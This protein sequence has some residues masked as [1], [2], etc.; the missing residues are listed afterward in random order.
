MVDLSGQIL[1][2]IRLVLCGW[3]LEASA[4]HPLLA[5]VQLVPTDQAQGYGG[6][7]DLDR[8][9]FFFSDQARSLHRIRSFPL[10]TENEAD[11]GEGVALCVALEGCWI[12]ENQIEEEE[13]VAE[14]ANP[15]QRK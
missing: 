11:D 5:K 2:W 10:E 12:H 4:R 8:A 6:E 14:E 3:R 1:C 7:Q 13:E 15:L 9:S